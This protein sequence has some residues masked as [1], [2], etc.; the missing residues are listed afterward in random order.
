MSDHN[1][2][3]FIYTT[4]A[5]AEQAGVVGRALISEKLAGCVNIFPQMLS[6]YEWQGRVESADEAAMIIKTRRGRLEDALA[7]TR[8][9]H[10]YETPALIVLPVDFTDPDYASWLIGAT[11][12]KSAAGD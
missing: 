7:R 4:F 12:G 1:D 6:I 9:M 2:I 11:T 5:N 3:V 8:E 10:P